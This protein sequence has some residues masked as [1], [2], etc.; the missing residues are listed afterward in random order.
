MIYWKLT[1]IETFFENQFGAFVKIQGPD[2]ITGEIY[3]VYL[4][5]KDYLSFHQGIP[6]NEALKDYSEETIKFLVLGFAPRYTCPLTNL[7]K[8]SQKAY[9]TNASANSVFF[10]AN[11]YLNN[12]GLSLTEIIKLRT[13][14]SL[15]NLNDKYFS[16]EELRESFVNQSA[17][18]INLYRRM[19]EHDRFENFV[20]GL[21][22]K[23]F[24]QVFS[25]YETPMDVVKN[26]NRRI[27]HDKFECISMRKDYEESGEFHPNTGVFIENKIVKESNF[28]VV[29]QD[30][31]ENLKMKVCKKCENNHR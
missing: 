19:N 15:G 18:F 11:A 24:S 27:F 30:Y 10:Y 6:F 22:D 3:R 20:A 9:V 21:D 31:L 5:Y 17:F 25:R 28:Y 26:Y 23:R 14:Y 7:Q 2:V 13:K 1:C 29:E 4:K 8:V 16:I 12:L